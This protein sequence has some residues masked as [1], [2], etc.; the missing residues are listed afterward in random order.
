[1]HRNVNRHHDTGTIW[2]ARLGALYISL[3]TEY[4]SEPYNGDDEDGEVQAGIDSGDFVYFD[5]K[6]SVELNGVEIGASYLGGSHYKSGEV[7]S[8]LHDGYFR[9]MLN[10]ACDA[11]RAYVGKLPKLRT[12]K[13]RPADIRVFQ[14]GRDFYLSRKVQG[15]K[16]VTAPMRVRDFDTAAALDARDWF[17]KV[18]CARE[19]LHPI[20]AGETF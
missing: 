8:F 5:S 11:A 14:D 10:E 15:E 4:S 6:V 19:N 9:D 1:M 3:V 20:F 16:T 2:S 7:S 13:G 17:V 18:Y 12:V